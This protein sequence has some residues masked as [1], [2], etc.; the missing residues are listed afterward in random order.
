M[1]ETHKLSFQPGLIVNQEFL[2][3]ADMQEGAKNWLYHARFRFGTGE[4]YGRHDG[5]QLHNLQLGHSDR[6]E[7]MMIEGLAPKNCLTIG[8]FQKSPGKACI[9]FLK[10][11]PWDIIIIDD[12]KPYNFVSND[13]TLLT[14]ISIS[15]SLVETDIPWLLSAID[16]KFTDK[17]NILFNTIESEWKHILDEPNL[18]KDPNEIEVMERKIVE[19]I[20]YAFTGQTGTGCHLTEGEKIAFEIKSFLLNSL[21]ESMTIQS[22]TEQ[23]KVSDKTLESSF[24]SLFG[25]TP[26][27]FLGLLKLNKA[28]EELQLANIKT[29]RVGNIATKWGYS[30]FGR[31]A[32]QHKAI[33]GEFPSETLNRAPA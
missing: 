7:G 33:F 16:K 28:H 2:N 11:E 5:V 32:K 26:K 19:A 25:I 10:V 6:H 3:Y 13:R 17:G 8:I 22:I 29:T 27:R 20:K 15:K 9:N 31:F 1:E 30:N 4:F 14:V 24:K 21:E 23:F 18:L 12:S